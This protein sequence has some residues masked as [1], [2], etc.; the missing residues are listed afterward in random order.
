MPDSPMPRQKKQQP[1]KLGMLPVPQLISLKRSFSAEQIPI[2]QKSHNDC[3]AAVDAEYA[4]C[5]ATLDGEI[6]TCTTYLAAERRT[7]DSASSRFRPPT[8]A[9]TTIKLL[10]PPFCKLPAGSNLFGTSNVKMPELYTTN[11]GKYSGIKD[12]ILSLLADMKS[13]ATAGIAAE[14]TRC[15]GLHVPHMSA[16]CE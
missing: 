10:E 6:D 15:H 11:L 8:L 7:I 14:C 12:E 9:S 3:D 16:V 5:Q 4:S 2:L 1:V 13:T